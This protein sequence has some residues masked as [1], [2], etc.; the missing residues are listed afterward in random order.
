MPDH[1]P[2]IV[3]LTEMG[4]EG[5]GVFPQIQGAVTGQ[6]FDVFDGDGRHQYRID[7]GAPIE[8]RPSPIYVNGRLYAVRRDDFDVPYVVGLEWTAPGGPD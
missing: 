1:R 6:I 7:F 4:G 8:L 2:A 5:V 3:R